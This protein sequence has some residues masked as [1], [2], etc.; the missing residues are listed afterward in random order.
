L[1]RC[2][3]TGSSVTGISR[4]AKNTSTGIIITVTIKPLSPGGE[5]AIIAAP[6]I[7][8]Q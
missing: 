4:N 8:E 3:N 6:G 7:E 5:L 1:Q 2:E